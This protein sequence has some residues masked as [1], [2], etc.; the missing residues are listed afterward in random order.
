MNMKTKRFQ[1]IFDR[2]DGQ[3]NFSESELRNELEQIAKDNKFR[4]STRESARDILNDRT[5]GV[6]FSGYDFCDPEF[7]K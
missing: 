3:F 1:A 2:A 7:F 6:F 5:G 4:E